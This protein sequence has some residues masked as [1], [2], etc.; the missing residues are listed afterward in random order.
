MSTVARNGNFER[1]QHLPVGILDA[2]REPAAVIDENLC[3]QRANRSFCHV[4]G[5]SINETEGHTIYQLGMSQTELHKLQAMLTLLLEAKAPK[6]KQ[7]ILELSC[8]TKICISSRLIDGQTDTPPLIL[9]S[10]VDHLDEIGITESSQEDGWQIFRTLADATFEGIA[11]TQDGRFID[12]NDQLT[13]MFKCQRDDLLITPVIHCV[14]SEHRRL[15][16]DFIAHPSKNEL[17]ESLMLRKDGTVFPVE[18]RARLAQMNGR[19]TCILAIRNTSE[20]KQYKE[21]LELTQFTIDHASIGCTWIDKDG[22]FFYVNDQACRSFGYD[23]QELLQMSVMDIDLNFDSKMW[24]DYWALLL[25][26]KVCTFETIHQHKDGSSFPVKIK[27]NYVLFKGKEY[28]CAFTTDLTK[29]KEIEQL[30]ELT[31]FAIDRASLSCF[32]MEADGRFFYVNDKACQSLGY[33]RHELLQKNGY[34]IDP[35]F[36]PSMCLECWQLIVDKHVVTFETTHQ[37]KDGTIFP[38]EIT[39]NYVNFGGKEYTCLFSRDITERKQAEE[40]LRLFRFSIDRASEAIFWLNTEG[41]FTY[42][43]DQ[44]CRSLQYSR[45]ELLSLHLWDIDPDFHPERLSSHWQDMREI[46][47]Q[48]IETTHQRKDGTV[49]PIEV[50]ANHI[51]FGD[52]EHHVAFVRDISERKEAEMEKSRLESQL[53]QSQKMES[54]GRLAGGVAHDFNNM[55]GVILGYAELMKLNMADSD[56]LFKDLIQIEKAA[57]HSKDITSQ[58]L[59]FSRKQ[60][61]SPKLIDLNDLIITLHKTLA[62]LI[63]EDVELQFFP[64]ENL[65]K[66]KFDPTQIEQILINLSANARDAMSTGGK[67]TIKTDNIH[68]DEMFCLNHVGFFPGDFVQLSLSDNGVGMDQE[69]LFHVF[70]PF[71]TTKEVGKGTGLGLATVYGIVQQGG[72]LID[73]YSEPA[74]GT[75]FKIYFPRTTEKRQVDTARGEAP[76]DAGTETVLLVED[77]K[78]VREMTRAML[79]EIGYDVLSIATPQEA[80]TLL[81]NDSTSI[82]LL[83]T[84]V[85]MP[86]MNG[87]ELHDRAVAIRPNI[88]TLFMSGYTA[89]V[90]VQHGMLD[91]GIHFIQKPFSLNNLARKI[92][93]ALL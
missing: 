91:E 65:W 85:V 74:Q 16:T 40:E 75:T 1:T 10:I 35:G 55:L 25:Q 29:R 4:F 38:V 64:A 49:F 23:R 8:F 3:I 63:G 30:L 46:G 21:A 70:E 61:I 47:Y 24:S 90:I 57:V 7:T 14:A 52:R 34:D 62:R 37:H 78:M 83:V 76:A 33:S 50:S 67:L 11:L 81:E 54:I 12:L 92:R 28:S 18:I 60:V 77:D 80:L 15:V 69:T 58:L 2:M 53:F 19:E 66:T 87:K 72:G 39:A 27:A 41:R 36:T 31:Q 71:F 88:K 32:W 20:R 42:V 26:D 6:G 93:N 82:Q 51:R 9:L 44:A 22:R 43:N 73:V 56:P 59:A 86:R 45:E 5:R 68:L 84:D 13:Q 89:N 79:E 48:I 17:C